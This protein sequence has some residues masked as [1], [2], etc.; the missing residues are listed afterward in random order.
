MADFY[1]QYT[2]E[3]NT[4]WLQRIQQQQSKLAPYLH[5]EEFDGEKKRFD[6][7][8]STSAQERTQRNGPTP[9][10]S[11]STD[12]R[13]A[14]RKSFDIPAKLI[15]RDDEQNLGPLVLPN[16]DLVMAHGMTYNREFDKFVLR[17]AIGSV[18][19]GT[20]GSVTTPY[21][22]NYQISTGGSLTI[23]KIL[24]AKEKMATA[25]VN[26]ECTPLFVVHPKQVTALLNLTEVKSA[27]YNTVKAL[28]NGSIDTFCGFKFVQSTQVAVA[29]SVYSCVAFHPQALKIT[30]GTLETHIDRRSDLSNSLQI[31]SYFRLAGTRVHD[32][33]VIEVQCTD[34]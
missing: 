29:G 10:A 19:T 11:V 4:N 25:E 30:R 31:Y 15:D 8:G 2:T 34:S 26:D 7:L 5:V 6:R 1:N 32:E 21:D 20:D 28:A 22:T 16:S 23:A 12:S 14:W 27:D 33:A 13:W 24:Q 3:F 9:T 18:R 17:T